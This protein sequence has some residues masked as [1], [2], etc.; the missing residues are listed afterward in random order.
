MSTMQVTPGVRQA[1]IR[2]VVLNADGTVKQD[3]GT[4]AYWHKNPLRRIWW[5]VSKFFSE[6]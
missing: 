3:L 2:A 6:V 1:R 5:R 4:V